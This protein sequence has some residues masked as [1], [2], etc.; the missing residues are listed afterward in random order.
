MPR[1]LVVEGGFPAARA[2]TAALERRGMDV[3]CAY[4]ELDAVNMEAQVQPNLVLMNLTLAGRNPQGIAGVMRANGRLGTTPL[5]VY[6][7]QRIEPARQGISEQMSLYVTKRSPSP[8]VQ[9]RILDF[10]DEVWT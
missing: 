10:L 8:V 6:T 9:G 3:T 2:L 7:Y 1:V 5:F 4:S